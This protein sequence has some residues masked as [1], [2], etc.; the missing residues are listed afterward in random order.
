[1]A[2][3]FWWCHLARV[4]AS[5]PLFAHL[6][7]GQTR[8]ALRVRERVRR[9][10]AC[11]PGRLIGVCA[12]RP[13]APSSSG[14]RGPSRLFLREGKEA[15][16]SSGTRRQGCTAGT[17]A[18][19]SGFI[20]DPGGWAPPS[21]ELVPASP[22]AEPQGDR[23]AALS[24]VPRAPTPSFLEP[25]RPDARRRSRGRQMKQLRFLSNGRR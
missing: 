25:K 23:N 24:S 14:E 17:A 2:V 3:S 4:T 22:K 9:D 1:M 11:S 19:V 20:S 6:H 8:C 7:G 13:S 10:T 5:K 21:S 15:R 16:N 18:P 12:G